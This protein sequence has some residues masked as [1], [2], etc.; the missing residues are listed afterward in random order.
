MV[1]GFPLQLCIIF[2]DGIEVPVKMVTHRSLKRNQRHYFRTQASTLEAMKEN[3]PTMQPKEV[4]DTTY[5]HAGGVLNIKSSSEVCRDPDQ[6]QVYNIKHSR[7]KWIHLYS[8]VPIHHIYQT[9][10]TI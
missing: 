1:N 2:F 4:V 9:F 6:T 7:Q 5:K 3:L 10:V 8:I